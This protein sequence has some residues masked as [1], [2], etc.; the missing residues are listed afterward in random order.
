MDCD[1]N[2]FITMQNLWCALT[3]IFHPQIYYNHPE[4]QTVN[5]EYN[6]DDK[7]CTNPD[8]FNE[9]DTDYAEYGNILLQF[10]TGTVSFVFFSASFS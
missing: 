8:F 3:N 7:N 1:D 6:A 5:V 10:L 9:T 4:A 2:S